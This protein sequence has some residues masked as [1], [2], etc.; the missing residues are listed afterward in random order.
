[1]RRKANVNCVPSAAIR[2]QLVVG[3][4]HSVSLGKPPLGKEVILKMVVV[5]VGINVFII[6]YKV[7]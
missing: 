7:P 4:V 3:S 2:S 1:M 6:Y 5:E